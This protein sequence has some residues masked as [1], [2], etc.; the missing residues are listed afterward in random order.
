MQIK[1]FIMGSGYVSKSKQAPKKIDS[2]RKK[3]LLDL[4]CSMDC[5]KDFG[6]YL[7]FSDIMNKNKIESGV[8]PCFISLKI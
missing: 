7:A 5:N 3:F 8:S 2:K 6:Q 1:P 4:F